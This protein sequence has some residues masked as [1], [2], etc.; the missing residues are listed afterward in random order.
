MGRGS[1]RLQVVAPA[2]K[3]GASG[4]CMFGPAREPNEETKIQAE[5]EMCS[6]QG[7]VAER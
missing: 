2:G 7:A 4:G 3:E 6:K 5:Q 1:W